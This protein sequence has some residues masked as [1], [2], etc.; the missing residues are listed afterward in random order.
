[1]T[2]LAPTS[3]ATPSLQSTLNRARVDAARREADQ[4]ESYAKTLRG[5]AQEQ[6]RVMVQ[7]RERVQVLENDVNQNLN[8]VKTQTPTPPPPPPPPPTQSGLTD[9]AQPSPTTVELEQKSTYS[10]LLAGVFE[11]AKPILN[12]DLSSTQKSLVQS[13]LLQAVNQAWSASQTPSK[14][15]ATYAVQSSNPA[16]SPT[17][18]MLN[19]SA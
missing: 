12:A 7:A 4:A 18:Q 17:G 19:T 8:S 10:G 11:A 14:V 1:M 5:Q 6:E 13:S 2:A 3:S 9:K 16:T 15:Q